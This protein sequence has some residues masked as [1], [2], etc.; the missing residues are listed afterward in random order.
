MNYS[1]PYECIKQQGDVRL[2][3]CA[4]EIF[5]GGTRIAPHPRLLGRTNQYSTNESHMPPEHQEYLQWN[6]ERFLRWGKQIGPNTAAVV[7]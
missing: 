7:K 6:A 1:V 5:F 4:V 2:I 3:L